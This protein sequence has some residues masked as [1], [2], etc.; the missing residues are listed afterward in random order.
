M[1]QKTNLQQRKIQQKHLRNNHYTYTNTQDTQK[2]NQNIHRFYTKN[3]SSQTNFSPNFISPKT[4]TNN[5]TKK[6]LSREKRK[7]FAPVCDACVYKSNS[8][9][10]DRQTT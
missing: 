3:E 2:Q 1:K 4:K 8:V 9:R 7:A 10:Q 6:K 5:Q